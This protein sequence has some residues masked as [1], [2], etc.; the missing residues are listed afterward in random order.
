MANVFAK[1]FPCVLLEINMAESFK[2]KDEKFVRETVVLL[3]KQSNFKDR[4]SINT[5]DEPGEWPSEDRRVTVTLS[6]DDIKK[7]TDRTVVRGDAIKNIANQFEQYGCT[8]EITKDQI[9]VTCPVEQTD[10][11]TLE[12][13]EQSVKEQE[14][15]EEDWLKRNG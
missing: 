8:T 2:E 11:L 12:E 10:A 3:V 1:Q 5:G 4:I 15:E 13:L 9:R 6:K 14:K 7:K